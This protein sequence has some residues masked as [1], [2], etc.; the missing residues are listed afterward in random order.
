MSLF[1]LTS[2]C[3]SQPVFIEASVLALFLPAGTLEWFDVVEGTHTD[4]GIKLVLEEKNIPPLLPEHEG[5]D[6]SS[7]GFYDITITDFPIRGKRT[8]LVFRRRRWK[9]EGEHE[10]LK[11]DI[12]LCAPGTQLEAEFADFL[13]D[14]SRDVRELFD[15]YC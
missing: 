14:A 13:K 10:L 2:S 3:M 9:V 12:Q 1:V 6:V 7:K 8:S 5:K 4:G 15:E 11:R